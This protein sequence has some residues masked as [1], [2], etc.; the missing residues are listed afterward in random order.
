MT[1]PTPAPRLTLRQLPLPAKLVVTAFLLTV[2]LGY[3]TALVQMHFQHANGSGNPMPT[4]SDVVEVFAGKK[5][6][7]PP[8]AGRE[9]ARP[10]SKLE[11]LVMGPTRG[12]PFNGSGSMAPAFF[13]RSPEY[14]QAV[15]TGADK[16]R[17]DAERE[18]ERRVVQ[19]WIAAEPDVRRA[20]FEADK[21][22]APA[23]K[24]P[25]AVTAKFVHPGTATFFKVK[26]ILDARCVTCH[27]AGGEQA[28]Y[29][30]ETYDQLNKYLD[31]PAAAAAPPAEGTW[32]D[33]D[34][35]MSK[36]KLAQSTHAH[37]LSFA[38]LFSLTGIV[39]AF[40]NYPGVV[41]GVLGPLVLVAQ[42]ADVSCWWLARLDGPGV[43][44]AM[45]IVG[46]G[47]VVG[48]GLCAQIV[49]STFNMY[50]PRGKVVLLAVFAGGLGLGGAAFQTVVKP[51]LEKEKQEAA[52]RAEEAK[53][54][55]EKAPEVIPP[56]AK[57]KPQDPKA[58]QKVES[59]PASGPSRMEVAFT[60]R[61]A[62]G[63]P[64]GAEPGGM[65]RAFYDK[66][67]E[68]KA[69]VKNKDA[70]LLK[71]LTPQRDGEHA[72]LL[73]WVKA[74]ADVRRAAYEQDRFEL[75]AD[76]RGKPMTPEFLADD[77]SVKVKT[78]IELRCGSCHTEGS[79][80]PS[81][82]TFSD[83]EQF[84]QPEPAGAKKDAPAIPK[85]EANA[86]PADAPGDQPRPEGTRPADPMALTP[87]PP[88]RLKK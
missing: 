18:G 52:K 41:R 82:D 23:D 55:Q 30:L 36:E 10:V 27:G 37:L 71:E 51:Q 7:V 1:D 84:L 62:E 53:K 70:E 43:Y 78:L 85:A 11:K 26:S 47:G 38:V 63:M 46:T 13:D 65:I 3:T 29:P 79:N 81:F 64:W 15:A 83:M 60:G 86:K 20:A 8:A 61:Y 12:V 34:R 42:V 32:V 21:F 80:A 74:P 6:Y 50:G 25:P 4:M 17:L 39:F 57:P 54:A 22:E 59:K 35:Q 73:A 9:P 67:T 14:K 77:K 69:A 5:K 68:Y 19:A 88:P 16:A 48:L 58:E 44:F 45:A 75:P 24:V 31:V 2:G 72:A 66:E 40:T 56:A 28:S 49:L 33:S 76:R 87:A